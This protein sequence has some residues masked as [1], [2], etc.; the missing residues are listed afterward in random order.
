MYENRALK[1]SGAGRGA[2]LPIKGVFGFC[3]F[4]AIACTALSRPSPIWTACLAGV[5]LLALLYGIVATVYS[6][7]ASRAFWLG[8]A[9]FGCVY[10]TLAHTTDSR[11]ETQP[12]GEQLPT[13]QLL[14][15]LD[16]HFRSEFRQIAGQGTSTG[17]AKT[18]SRRRADPFSD[19]DPFASSDSDSADS[20][21]RAYAPFGSTALF[22]PPEL[23]AGFIAIGHWLF[24][25]FFAWLGGRIACL[26]YGN[27]LAGEL[28][29]HG[30]SRSSARRRRRRRKRRNIATNDAAVGSPAKVPGDGPPG[31]SRSQEPLPRPA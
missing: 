22:P 31:L 14:R 23:Q 25:L 6:S 26:A 28:C 16:Q 9:L 30:I 7:G 3:V 11:Y 12:I 18:Q 10:L 17:S 4:A 29:R 19:T 21:A 5:V 13:T 1:V 2:S 15:A 20:M 24:T 27:H 8:F